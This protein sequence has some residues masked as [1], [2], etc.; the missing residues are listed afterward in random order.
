MRRKILERALDLLSAGGYGSVSMQKLAEAC[1]VTKPTI[2]YHFG[3]K[4]GLFSAMLDL[5]MSD[6]EARIGRE[7]NSSLSVREGVE[8]LLDCML[9]S[10]QPGPRVARVNLAFSTDPGLRT[11]FPWMK[12]RME[13]LLDLV[14]G[15]MGKGVSMGELREDIDIRMAAG[16][17]ISVVRTYLTEVAGEG[18]DAVR[19]PPRED[20]V[21]LFFNGISC[22]R[23]A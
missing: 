1:G 10:Q 21:D 2:Y 15:L 16:F 4:R 13:G 8:R 19:I 11:M 23:G 20:I 14:S 3:S 7:L 22:E 9:Y 17:L 18:G 6:L 5:V 12:E